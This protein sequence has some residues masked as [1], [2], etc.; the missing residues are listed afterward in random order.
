MLFSKKKNYHSLIYSNIY[1][2]KRNLISEISNE[3]TNSTEKKK[4]FRRPLSSYRSYN[5]IHT[6][7]NNFFKVNQGKK[8]I[9]LKYVNNINK[10]A[11]NKGLNLG[12]NCLKKSNSMKYILNEKNNFNLEKINKEMGF[13]NAS[14]SISKDVNKEELLINK[15]NQIKKYLNKEGKKILFETLKKILNEDRILNKR[16]NYND[17][18]DRVFEKRRREKNFHKLAKQ[19]IIIE[20]SYG[21]KIVPENEKE[22][23]IKMSK[24]FVNKEKNS[25]EEMETNLIKYQILNDIDNQLNKKIKKNKY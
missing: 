22:L 23:I 13:D 21:K 20:K 18:F 7:K 17:Q 9:I 12:K 8:R 14:E 10:I 24:K 15:T 16:V 5:N 4:E 19:S 25:K 2:N 11:I 6:N 3:L 1:K